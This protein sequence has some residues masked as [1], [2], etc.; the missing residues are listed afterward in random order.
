MYQTSKSKGQELVAERMVGDFIRAGYKAFLIT[1]AF[2]DG[3]EVISS[4]SLQV[5]KKRI[6]IDD[7]TLEIPVIR[8]DSY[9][10]RWPPRRVNFP[11]FYLEPRGHRRRT[12]TE[13]TH[14]PL[15][16]LERP[17][18]NRQVRRL[19]EDDA[20]PGRIQRPHR[21]LPHVPFSGAFCRTLYP[22]GNE[23]SP[24]LE[25]TGAHQDTGDCQSGALCYS[26]RKTDDGLAGGEAAKVL[27]FS[28][29]SGR[30]GINALF[31]RRYRRVP[32]KVQNPG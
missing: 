5:S 23:L 16:A 12:K 17:G 2:H 11:R 29:W 30:C 8:V 22:S 4:Q 20:E 9:I 32:Q 6:M 21:F 28:R 7:D 1:S 18:G 24:G 26:L 14:H 15:D 25:Q 27:P 13:R 3:N 10:A 19:E 31:R